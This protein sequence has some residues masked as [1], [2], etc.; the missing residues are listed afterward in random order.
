[1]SLP[2]APGPC[3]RGRPR[4]EGVKLAILQAAGELILEVG[5]AGFTIEGVAERAG[6]SKVTIYKWWPSKGALA[7]DGF[8]VAIAP[9]IEIAPTGDAETDLTAQVESVA[10]VFRDARA[11]SL[12]AGLIGEAQRDPELAVA[13]HDRWLD[14]RRRAGAEI[15]RSGQAHGEFRTDLDLTLV[16]DQIYGTLYLRLLLGH[17]PIPAGIG[18]TIVRNVVA[19]IRCPSRDAPPKGQSSAA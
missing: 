14:P 6:A 16:L 4:S 9:A 19:G 11:G 3:R 17:A 12:L 8:F 10:G 2:G 13:L 5:L 7:L 1:M 15:L 18:T